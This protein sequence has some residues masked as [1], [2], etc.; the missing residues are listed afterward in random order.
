M[1][2]STE[3]ILYTTMESPIGELLL[4]G[5]GDNLSGLYMQAGRKPG[6]IATGWEPSTEPFAGVKTQLQEYFAGDRT[7]FDVPLAAEGAPFELEVWHA[8]EEIPYGET[9][10]Y[11]EIARRVGQPTAARAVGTANGRNPIAVIV[12]CHRVIGADGSLT[13][14]GGGLERKRLLLE[15][16]QGQARLQL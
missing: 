2:T 6:T 16:E 11:G 15:L 3:Q 13:G 10:S 8:L 9:V 4:V 7:T 5:D 12:P 14:Y 1:P